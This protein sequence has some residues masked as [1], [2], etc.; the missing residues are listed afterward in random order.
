[1]RQSYMGG[2]HHLVRTGKRHTLFRIE[3]AVLDR[4]DGGPTPKPTIVLTHQHCL[5]LDRLCLD[6]LDGKPVEGVS[7]VPF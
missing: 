5:E 2:A 3:R 1:M 4:L 7:V 6:M